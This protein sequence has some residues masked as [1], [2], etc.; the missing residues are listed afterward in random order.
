MDESPQRRGSRK[1]LGVRCRVEA[2]G[3]RAHP[4]GGGSGPPAAAQPAYNR[5]TRLAPDAESDLGI[6][7]D[8]YQRACADLVLGVGDE[9][10]VEEAERAVDALQRQQRR[11]KAAATLLGEDLGLIRDSSGVRLS[12]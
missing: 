12:R 4:R 10:R 3:R 11:M 2:G 7:L 1:Q 9:D 5:A 8:E 6:A